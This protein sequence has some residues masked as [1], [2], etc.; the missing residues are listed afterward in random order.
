M[1]DSVNGK[2]FIFPKITYRDFNILK[3]LKIDETQH[4]LILGFILNPNGKHGKGNMFLNEFFNVVL[5]DDNFV[6]NDSDEWYVT[7][8]KGRFD[9]S[10][11][12]KNNTKIIIIENKSN[13]AEDQNN[14]L[15]RYW[16]R[17]IYQA[18]YRLKKHGENVYSKIIYLSPSYEKQYT[19]Q[20]ITRPI[21]D[22]NLP[23][24]IPEGI[25]KPVY[26][27]A[28]IVKWLE[29]CMSILEESGEKS[30]NIYFY[31]KQYADY[32]RKSMVNEMSNQI[33]ELFNDK[34][35]WISFWN[36]AQKKEDIRKAWWESFKE[37]VIK[38]FSVDNLVDGW[39][40]TSSE[41]WEFKWFLKEYGEKSL[42]LRCSD[43]NGKYS[44]LLW[45]DPNLYDTKKIDELLDETK[46]MPI[47]SAFERKDEIP[48]DSNVIIAE[49][50]NYYFGDEMDGDFGITRLAW[51]AHYKP[52]EF[53]SQIINKIDKFR[54]NNEVTDLLK[55]LNNLKK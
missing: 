30:E 23:E 2:R 16:L 27:R 39:D 20:S 46:Y 43:W 41:A 40:F 28:S 3:Q 48:P 54:K 26:F 22:A 51:Y 52:D 1:M 42:C 38:C 45:A 31:I 21:F 36:L 29:K 34:D 11:R 15:Y 12:N 44:L 25:I 24:K 55:E 10:I 37:S 5:A 50:G 47:A 6:H 17:G 53:I 4:S 9:I 35:Q 13:W 18:Q 33:E 32:W 8:E 19:E 7:V 14:Q 49:K